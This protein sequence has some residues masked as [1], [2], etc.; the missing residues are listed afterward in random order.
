MR[1]LVYP[2]L[3]AGLA[4]L[5]SFSTACAQAPPPSD[6]PTG[7]HVVM[8][9]AAHPDDED[10]STL[11][12]YRHVADDVAYSVIYT[13]GEGGQNEIGPELYEA[14]GAL[15]T[16]ETERAARILGTQVFFLNYDDFGYS[17][18]ATEAFE[19]WGGEDDVTASLV[20]LIRK[21]KPDVLF[22]NHDTVTV[23]QR[24]HGHHQAV[25]ISAYNAFALAADA[26]YRP[27]QLDEPGVDLWQPKRLFLR[28]WRPRV[29]TA[30]DVK[31]PVSTPGASGE[32]ASEIAIR[33]LSQHSSQ[34][35]DFF[36]KSGR[37]RPLEFTYFR[38]LRSATD[39][40]LDTLDIAGNLPPN[41]HVGT[42]SIPYRLDSGRIPE[43]AEE[44]L[45]IDSPVA[46]PGASVQLALDGSQ[47]P[48]TD[49][50][51]DVQAPEGTT[52]ETGEDLTLT[53]T[54]PETLT[55][56][57]PKQVQQYT[58]LT[59]RPPIRYVLRERESDRIVAGGYAPVEI[60]PPLVVDPLP[61][62]V[63]IAKKPLP[64]AVTGTVYEPDIE[65]VVGSFET[66]DASGTVLAA[67]Q[68]QR[69]VPGS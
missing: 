66:V 52:M 45:T 62:A 64:F 10:G 24:Q 3:L 43:L 61:D 32:P 11:A 53:L 28:L 65:E 47:L 40:P 44:A 29:G 67:S 49:M 36:V 26:S 14:L 25:G 39:A 31:V 69:A 6:Q 33:A 38:L 17:K 22:T 35:M 15:R 60:A 57:L 37:A 30:Y 19:R 9:L 12:Y 55:P 58:R 42:T 8:N 21:L 59:S 5:V 34:G 16:T 46:T 48:M 13:R 63:R 68:P 20:R 41:P 51:W 54:L 56:T 50:Y 23:G 2:A 1:R 4:G 18:F 27:E 7:Q